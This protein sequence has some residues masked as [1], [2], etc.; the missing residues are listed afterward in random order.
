MIPTWFVNACAT[1]AFIFGYDCN[2]H[3]RSDRRGVKSFY[4]LRRPAGSPRPRRIGPWRGGPLVAVEPLDQ[5][6][7]L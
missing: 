1:V 7:A 4:F 5:P 6:A 3:C 2:C